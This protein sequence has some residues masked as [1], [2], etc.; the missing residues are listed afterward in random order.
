MKRLGIALVG[1]WTCVC[2]MAFMMTACS[3]GNR[4]GFSRQDAPGGVYPAGELSGEPT[5]HVEYYHRLY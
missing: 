2:I 1:C 5:Y 4:I 3:D